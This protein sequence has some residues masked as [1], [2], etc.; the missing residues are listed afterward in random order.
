MNI[1]QRIAVV[2]A[3]ALAIPIA[4]LTQAAKETYAAQ[5]E[6]A[7]LLTIPGNP[8]APADKGIKKRMPVEVTG[9]IEQGH[10]AAGGSFWV[11][12]GKKKQYTIR[13]LFDL[14]DALQTELG[15]IA[16]SRTRV[17]VRGILKVWKDGSAAFDDAKPV[18]ISK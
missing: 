14:D 8:Q 13:Y 9:T 10:D 15:K 6:Q 4:V 11:N 18:T 5:Q 16:D 12:G 17:K 2:T 1:V 7:L 3:I